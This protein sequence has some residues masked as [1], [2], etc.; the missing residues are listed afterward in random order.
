VWGCFTV[1]VGVII[2]KVQFHFA[3]QAKEATTEG[4][5]PLVEM[6]SKLRYRQLKDHFSDDEDD[7]E[8]DDLPDGEVDVVLPDEEGSLKAIE[9]EM[10]I[11]HRRASIN[12]TLPNG[13]DHHL[14]DSSD[15]SCS[16]ASPRG[17]PQIV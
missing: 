11:P 7:F 15:G 1:F 14:N 2:Y 12:A 6:Q 13:V 10:P 5:E 3:K 17:S 9:I 16:R 4:D 8:D